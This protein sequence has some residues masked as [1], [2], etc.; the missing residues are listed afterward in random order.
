MSI[1]ILSLL[2]IINKG[3]DKLVVLVIEGEFF[4]AGNLSF[5][6]IIYFSHHT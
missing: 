2:F 6:G 5:K 1:I 3:K 4:L